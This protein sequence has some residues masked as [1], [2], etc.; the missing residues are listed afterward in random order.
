[1]LKTPNCSGNNLI[2]LLVRLNSCKRIKMYQFQPHLNRIIQQQTISLKSSKPI[3]PL[4]VKQTKNHLSAMHNQFLTVMTLRQFGPNLNSWNE[5][6][7]SFGNCSVKMKQLCNRI[8]NNS[9]KRRIF[10]WDFAK[11]CYLQS[12]S[13]RNKLGCNR[14]RR[15][16][17]MAVSC[18]MTCPLLRRI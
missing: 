15:A 6:I 8:L 7:S 5:R 14:T 3:W 16:Q 9:R 1:M 17:E 11:H 2:N 13:S 18:C 10:R 4:M 12:K